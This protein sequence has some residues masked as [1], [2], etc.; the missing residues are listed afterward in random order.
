MKKIKFQGKEWLMVENAITTKEWYEAGIVSYAHLCENGDIKRYG[1]VVGTKDDIE[2]IGDVS[3]IEMGADG[4]GNL[5]T[6]RG[7]G[8]PG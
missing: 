7:W 4:I 6:G 1:T 3:D 2:F 8:F 5:L